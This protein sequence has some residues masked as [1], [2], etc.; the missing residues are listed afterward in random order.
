MDYKL[1]KK[2]TN[3]ELPSLKRKITALKIASTKNLKEL[4]SRFSPY[5]VDKKINLN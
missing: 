4:D 1:L 5:L 2:N 3:V